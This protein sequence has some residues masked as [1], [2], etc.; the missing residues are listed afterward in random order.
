[1]EYV[2]ENERLRVTLTRWGAQIK[3]VIHK[4]DQVEHMW[5]ADPDV[6]KFHSP[7]LFPYTG[8]IKDGRIKIRGRNVENAPIHGLVRT[9]MYDVVQHTA[10]S[11]TFAAKACEETLTFFPYHF[12]LLVT[13]RLEGE[14]LHQTITIENTD[15]E[16]FSFG[17]GFHPG[18]VIPFDSNHTALDYE[19]RFSDLESPRCLET[20]GGLVNGHDYLLGQNLHALPITDG[21]FNAGSHC[22]VGL[23]SSTVGIYEKGSGRAV[24]CEV[25]GH[26]YCLLWS[27]PGVPRF[28]CIE[29]WHSLPD[30]VDTDHDWNGKTAAAVLQPGMSWDVTMK[31]AFVR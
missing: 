13:F 23:N 5:Q 27:Q 8:R 14:W 28:V 17:M 26:P 24:L 2:I 6:W 22:M 12:R 4:A 21:M 16:C 11:V 20:P 18:F 3:S 10:H 29:P 7:I 15:I 1:M 31:L 30:R 9:L 25:K 19:I